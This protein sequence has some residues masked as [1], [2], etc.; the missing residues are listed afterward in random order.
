MKIAP[1]NGASSDPSDPP[2]PTTYAPDGPLNVTKEMFCLG[3]PGPLNG[4]S[5]VPN[6]ESGLSVPVG[7]SAGSERVITFVE[8][9]EI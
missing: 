1:K 3:A 9:F 7:G 4:H 2:P 5:N 6:F 8:P